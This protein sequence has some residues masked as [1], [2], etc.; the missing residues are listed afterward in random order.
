MTT[1]FSKESD[2]RGLTETAAAVEAGVQI[3]GAEVLDR[4]D[5]GAFVLP[6]GTTLNIVDTARDPKYTG[7]PER[8][9]GQALVWDA[10]SFNAFWTKYAGSNSEVYADVEAF[11]VNGV[12]NAHDATVDDAPGIPGW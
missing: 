6:A 9:T 8:A 11:T 10:L 5:L 4:G 1:P 12:I 3:A 7:I 2:R